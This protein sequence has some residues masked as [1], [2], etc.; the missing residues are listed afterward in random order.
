MWRL[1]SGKCVRRS[2]FPWLPFSRG[3]FSTR[4]LSW[5]LLFRGLLVALCAVKRLLWSD[6]VKCCANA[7]SWAPDAVLRP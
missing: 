5:A 7:V 4:S 1:V 6:D 3:L 2:L